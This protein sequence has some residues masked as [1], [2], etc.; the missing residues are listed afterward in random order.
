MT[1][2]TSQVQQISPSD[3][4]EIVKRRK[5]S[6]ILPAC[7][8]FLAAGLT[9]LLLPSIYI[10]S[11]TILIEE[12]KV[13][14]DFVMATVTSYVEQRLQAINQRI[15]SYS[16][17]K[18]VID[19]FDPYPDL[20]TRFTDDEIVVK[21][22]EDIELTP[23][24][25]D[26]M[27]RRTGRPTEATIAFMLSYEGKSPSKVQQIATVLASLFLEEN[28]KVRSQQTLETT[29][30]LEEEMN[31]V[32]NEITTIESN[33][34][35]FKERNFNELPELLQ[36]NLQSLNTLER[37]LERLNE[38]LRSLK[39]REGYLQTQLASIP[40]NMKSE[41][42]Q[43]KRSLENLKIH[44]IDLETQY[45][46]QYP[47]VINTKA[48]I[49]ELEKTIATADDEDST[50][51]DYPDNP[52][53][54]TLASQLASTESEIDS[55]KRQVKE[56]D[57]KRALYGRRIAATPNVEKQFKALIM[58]QASNQ[59]KYNDVMSKLMEARLAYGL[60]KE[61]KGERFSLIEPARLPE[62]PYKPNRMAILLIGLVLGVGAGVG[63]ASLRE[64]SDRS[65]KNIDE[66]LMAGFVPVMGSIPEIV[67]AGDR[68]KKWILLISIV[69][70]SLLVLILGV[71]G[72]HLFVMDL[73]VFWAKLIRKLVAFGIM[74]GTI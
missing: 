21:M 29:Q 30:F 5:W 25:A 67:T 41:M 40:V 1:P 49:Q 27:D 11:S 32:K 60:E 53:Y 56:L 12:Q 61:Q 70:L 10:S 63:M 72:F 19:Q 17:L 58:E 35:T 28:I 71:C 55:I 73:D 69:L 14:D 42:D 65:L 46:D 9:A 2:N 68:K 52:A 51:G 74:P 43:N 37:N 59:A 33:L 24:S 20:K 44:L 4:I 15:M 34:A 22:R 62:K 23:I 8:V 50:D 38:M 39:E 66:L 18:E 6:L 3:Y 31:R 48:S 45:S 64:F 54:I 57:K 26:T 47:D 16:R 7:L 13:P 36:A